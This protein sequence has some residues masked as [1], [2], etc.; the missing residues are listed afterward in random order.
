M[1]RIL[2]IDDEDD[3]VEI[4]SLWMNDLGFE[5]D[6]AD[7]VDSAIDM[8]RSGEYAAIFCDLKMPGKSGEALLEYIRSAF[9]GLA[10]KFVLITG[11]LV[12][13][14]LEQLIHKH[15]ASILRKPFTFNEIRSLLSSLASG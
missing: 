9:E 5:C 15:G 4:L 3:I 2:I 8:L 6:T 13:E 1:K 11:T 14:E 12:E 7:N 10:R